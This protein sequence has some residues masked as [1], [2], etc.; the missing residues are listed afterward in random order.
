MCIST[1][2]GVDIANNG[3]IVIIAQKMDQ[4]DH[5]SETHNNM[6]Q[7]FSFGVNFNAAPVIYDRTIAKYLNTQILSYD[8]GSVNI[9]TFNI[10]SINA[11]KYLIKPINENQLLSFIRI[12]YMSDI[13][14]YH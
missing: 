6:D 8:N 1:I 13:Y 14:D 7:N 3:I 11:N 5:L 2:F 10:Y 12:F 4:N 9:S